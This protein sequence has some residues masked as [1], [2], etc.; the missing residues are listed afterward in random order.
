MEAEFTK[1]M[2]TAGD[3]SVVAGWIE[4]ASKGCLRDLELGGKRL[5]DVACGTGTVAIEAASRG[6]EVTGVDITPRMLALARERA[7]KT[8]A[9]ISWREGSFTALERFGKFDIVTSAFGVI[10]AGED[11]V[12]VASE[13]LGSCHSGG[14]VSLTTWDVRGI[15]AV[16][17]GLLELM[18]MDDAYGPRQW[19]DAAKVRKIFEDTGRE[20]TFGE[21]VEDMILFHFDSIEHAFS[22]LVDVSGPWQ[23]IFGHLKQQGQGARAEE[24]MLEHL[25]QHAIPAKDGA[26]ICYEAFYNIMRIEAR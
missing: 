14:L 20:H 16:P 12:K 26:G 11:T 25:H 21:V 3:Y 22:Q 2:W 8:G 9:Q 5:L 23:M 4:E 13:L 17:A 15:N 18:G 1:Q 19:S 24:V 7:S 10:F 6:A